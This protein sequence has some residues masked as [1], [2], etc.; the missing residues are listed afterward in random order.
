MKKLVLSGILLFA[1]LFV[2]SFLQG[3]AEDQSMNTSSP[4]NDQLTDPTKFTFSYSDDALQGRTIDELCGLV[5]P[6]DWRETGIFKDPTLEKTTALPSKYTAPV[7]SIK[8]Q[9][10][11]GSCWSFATVG[12]VEAKILKSKGV[13]RN[14]SEQYLVSC[15]TY[16][17]GCNGGWF[18]YNMLTNGTPLES[19]YPYS[20]SDAYCKSGCTKY[21][22]VN[23]WYYISSSSSV[24]ST[25][26]IKTAIYNYGAVAAAVYVDS[27]FS[28]YTSGVFNRNA[29]GNVNHAIMLVGWDD[30]KGAWKL[31]N[32]WGTGWGESGYMW[33]KYGCQKVGYGANYVYSVK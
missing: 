14:L 26:A 2:I 31:K 30:S 1:A 17:Y 5:E 21:N 8:N 16:G 32:S 25:T 22:G 9:G 15:N 19:C 33:I 18:A 23:S 29:S 20:A 24:P 4:D 12:A 13:T 11:C 28:R 27:Y 10:N 7:T 6:A 3:C